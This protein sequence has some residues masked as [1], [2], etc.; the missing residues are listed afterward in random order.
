MPSSDPIT[1]PKVLDIVKKIDP[2]TILD[3]GSGN[4]RYGFLFREVMDFNWGRLSPESWRTT[5]DTVEVD[6]TYITPVHRYIYNNIVVSDWMEVE[7]GRNY[8]LIFMGD[9]LE[10]FSSWEHALD[11][12][13][14]YGTVVIVV[15]P[16]WKGSIAQGEWR[17]HLHETHLTELSPSIIGGRCL[18]ANSKCFISAFYKK[19]TWGSCVESRDIAL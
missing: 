8:D 11:K 7:P 13:K 6:E 2:I 10:H 15:A 5:I 17:G 14:K 19:D 12:A 18:F 4:G 1:I 16:N 3:I 9:V